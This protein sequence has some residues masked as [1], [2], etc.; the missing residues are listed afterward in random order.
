MPLLRYK[1]SSASPLWFPPPAMVVRPVVA[2]D[3]AYD[4]SKPE[5]T[6]V[7]GH[8]KSKVFNDLGKL[9]ALRGTVTSRSQYADRPILAFEADQFLWS[10]ETIGEVAS[11][12]EKDQ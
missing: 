6:F 7:I 8:N 12:I 4:S 3:W 9:F 2:A 11:A 10:S 5:I 1:T